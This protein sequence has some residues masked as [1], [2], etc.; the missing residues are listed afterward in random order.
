MLD[1]KKSCIQIDTD[2]P[3]IFREFVSGRDQRL[4]VENV[5]LFFFAIQTA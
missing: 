4:R 3:Q 1:L 5:Q 2:D